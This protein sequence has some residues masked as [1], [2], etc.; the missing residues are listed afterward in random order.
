[1][2]EGTSQGRRG[3][4]KEKDCKAKNHANEENKIFVWKDRGDYCRKKQLVMGVALVPFWQQRQKGL[5][6]M[7]KLKPMGG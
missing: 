3:R 1:M 5:L 6:L 7:R 2:E 4:G